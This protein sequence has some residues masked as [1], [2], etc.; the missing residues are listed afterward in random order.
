[1]GTEQITFKEFLKR[2][3]D[4]IRIYQDK[5][6]ETW[7]LY[8]SVD[9]DV[10]VFNEVKRQNILFEVIPEDIKIHLSVSKA[11]DNKSDYSN[12]EQLNFHNSNADTL[13]T[14]LSHKPTELWLDYWYNCTSENSR[15]IGAKCEYIKVEGRKFNK[16]GKLTKVHRVGFTTPSYFGTIRSKY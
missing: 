12:P 8:G 6:S 16:N 11:W 10:K 14:L 15:K 3:P 4:Y 2:D 5:D 13:K 7:R 1:M 9:T